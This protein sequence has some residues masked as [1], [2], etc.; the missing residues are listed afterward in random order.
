MEDVLELYAEA[1]DPRQPVVCFDERPCQMLA[2]TRPPLPAKPGQ[3]ERYDYEY[4]RNGTCNLFVFFQPLEGWRQVKVTERRTKQD[5][6]RCMKQLVDELFPQAEKIRVVM[7]NLSTHTPG[8]LYETFPPEEARRIIK[9]LEIHNVPK[10]GSWLNMVE[11]ELSVLANQCLSER[12]PDIVSMRKRIAVWESERNT[13][14][15]TVK[16]RFTV[17]N[18]RTKLGRLYIQN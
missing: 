3:P 8:A 9:K 2:E 17:V 12:I 7:D 18:A 13:K 15:A 4:K 14:K 6:A 5:F 10:H 1:F 16:W 11:I